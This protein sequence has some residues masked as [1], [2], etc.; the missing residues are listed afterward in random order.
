[1]PEILK[2]FGDL[3]YEDSAGSVSEEVLE[4]SGLFPYFTG[5]D[6]TDCI[7]GKHNDKNLKFMEIDLKV[8]QNNRGHSRHNYVSIFRG[9]I[10]IL[11]LEQ[12]LKGKTIIKPKLPND[13]KSTD[14]NGFKKIGIQDTEFE[15]IFEIF[16]NDEKEAKRL[17]TKDFTQNFLNIN[18][19]YKEEAMECSFFQNKL[20]ILLSLDAKNKD[21][22]YLEIAIEES[23]TNMDQIH[24]LL[25][26]I[27][28]ILKI[29]EISWQ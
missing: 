13:K 6:F 9:K 15:N 27:N 26:Q 22:D 4:E 7:T 28:G 3:K 1:M 2:F 23:L 18:N 25:G 29:S 5:V 17:L 10:I 11:E 16:S 21:S 12:N 8:R 14:E 19:L 24:K 20:M